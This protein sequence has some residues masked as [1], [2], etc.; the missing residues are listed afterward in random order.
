MRLRAGLPMMLALGLCV[1]GC[2]NTPGNEATSPEPSARVSAPAVTCPAA[3]FNGF[4]RQF[5]NHVDLQKAFVADPLEISA[6]DANAEPEPKAVI[7]QV[8]RKDVTFPLMPDEAK[9]RQDGLQRSITTISP[10]E[11]SV[12]LTKSD[13]DYQMSFHFSHDDCWH[14]DRVADES[15]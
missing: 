9:Q 2:G 3:D 7:R 8:S 13:T 6:I 11:A 12:K 10:T 14:L 15:L 4:L 1:S 5:E